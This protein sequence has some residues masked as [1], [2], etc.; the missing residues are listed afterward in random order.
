MKKMITIC[1]IAMM[2]AMVANATEAPA[3][4]RDNSV[5]SHTDVVKANTTDTYRLYFTKGVEAEILVIGDGDTDLDLYVY[6]ENGNLIEYDIDFGDDCYVS[7]TPKWSGYFKVKIKNLGNIS[8]R[9][10]LVCN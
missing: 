3:P 8:N 5:S 2:A 7:W 9:Y 1:M 4:S 10:L 6:D